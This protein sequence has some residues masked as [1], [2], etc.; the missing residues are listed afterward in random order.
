MPARIIT[1]LEMIKFQHSL[2][3]LPWAFVGAFY[4][5]RGVPGGR[6]ILWILAAMVS[7]R[8]AAMTFNRIADAKIDAANPR[9]EDRAIPRGLVSVP[10]AAAVTA[11]AIAAFV[12]S[13]AMLNRL[14]LALA[15]AAIAVL[16]GYSYTKRFT[17]LCHFALGLS[18]GM[19]PVG[20]WLG[21]R[22]EWHPLPPLVG[23]A[24]LFWIAGADILY[25]CEDVEFDR[26]HGIRSIPASLGIPRALLVARLSHVAAV[27]ALVAAGLAARLGVVFY[28][29]TAAVAALLAYEHAIVKP[30]DLRRVNRAFFHVNAVVSAAVFVACLGDLW[31]R[32]RL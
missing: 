11:L 24:V 13:A 14:C 4:A 28:A 32:G 15:P 5:A 18:L 8:T 7:A 30:D 31:Q 1:Y 26:A 12:L 3:A 10:F 22:P 17:P 16:L 21:V 9:T 6:E 29:G 2:F 23:T 20:A 19:A 25:A 27:G